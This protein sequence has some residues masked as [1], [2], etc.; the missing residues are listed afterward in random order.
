[1]SLVHAVR[2]R[3][4][5]TISLKLAVVLLVLTGL[6]ATI[7]TLNQA[8]QMEELTLEKARLAAA[9]GA[10]QY[11]DVFDAAIDSGLLTVGDVFDRSYVEIKGWDWGDKPKYHTRY[12]TFT[13]KAVLVFQDKF[14]EYQDF[15]F[16]VG[17]DENG[18]L[19]THN[20]RFQKPLTGAP[21]KDGP[22][23]RTKRIFDD[24]VGLAAAKNLQPGLQQVY[25]R[26]TGETMWDVSSPVYVKGKHWGGFRIGVSI[27]RIEAR[28]S[29]LLL[30]LAGIFA[31]FVLV[32]IATVFLVV[33]AAM[34]P[35]RAL[36]EAAEAISMGDGL[37][38]PVKTAAVDEIGLLTKAVD[39]L[40]IS[41]KAAISRLG[42]Q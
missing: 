3:L 2:T 19:P 34:R 26:D 33:Q 15:I 29:A 18:Y 7:I 9:L 5:A 17:V 20:T 31:V 11:G 38:V 25:K 42:G 40:R 28:R 21:G 1:M 24:P 8:R 22:S 14:L 35:V 36:T 32:T 23:N 6:A 16:A 13:D 37:D 39:R 27:E 10:R 30:T 41:M 4:G 12:D